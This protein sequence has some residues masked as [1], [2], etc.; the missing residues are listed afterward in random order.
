MQP[1]LLYDRT[2]VPPNWTQLIRPGQY[3]VFLND[4]ESSAPLSRDGLPIHFASEYF[5]LLFDSLGDAESYCREAVMQTRRLK[6]EVFDSAG[7]V[8]APVAVFVNPEFAHTLD[9]EAS[10][11]RLVRWGFAA[12]AISPPLFWYAW[13]HGAGIVWWPIL[14]GINAVFAGLRLIQW[15]SGL[16]EE[17]RYR[18]KEAASRLHRNALAVGG[19]NAHPSKTAKGGAPT[20][21]ALRTGEPSDEA[22]RTRTPPDVALRTG[23]K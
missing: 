14:L 2:R 11:R 16:K 9:T 19:S 13:K 1:V 3:A 4:V 10:A 6:C 17:L 8:N 7:R 23:G 21:V 22:V 20:N 15:G 12:I 5:C 18:G